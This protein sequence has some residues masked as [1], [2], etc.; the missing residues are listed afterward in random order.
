[1]SAVT[2]ATAIMLTQSA[3]L[4]LIQLVITLNAI[5][6]AG[7]RYGRIGRAEDLAAKAI[8]VASTK[9]FCDRRNLSGFNRLPQH[10]RSFPVRAAGRVHLAGV[11]QPSVMRGRVFIA[12]VT[13]FISSAR[14]GPGFVSL[15]KNIRSSHPSAD[16]HLPVSCTTIE[17]AVLRRPVESAQ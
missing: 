10:R 6:V 15:G 1:M 14:F 8:F 7:V 13:A 16:V 17:L 2:K 3:G 12:C 4:N 11:R 5:V 9:A